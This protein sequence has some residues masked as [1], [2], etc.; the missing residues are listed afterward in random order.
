MILG[1]EG[2]GSWQGT[3]GQEQYGTKPFLSALAVIYSNLHIRTISYVE[4][5]KKLL[6]QIVDT[7]YNIHF[8]YFN[9]YID[10]CYT[11]RGAI[12][13]NIKQ[14]AGL[15]MSTVQILFFYLAD[16]TLQETL[17]AQPSS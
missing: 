7:T 6:R 1:Y 14:C 3:V 4:T 16:D 13:R 10:T 15:N 8:L 11:V 12:H 2:S 5:S 9:Y 17:H